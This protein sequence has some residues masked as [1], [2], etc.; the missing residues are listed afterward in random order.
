MFCWVLCWFMAICTFQTMKRQ[1][2]NFLVDDEIMQ[3]LDDI[4]AMRRPV[5]TVSEAI[6]VAILNERDSLKKKTD[7][8][9]GGK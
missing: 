4:R 6:R 9:K 7:G 8:Q 3:A 2:I 1:Q 5:P